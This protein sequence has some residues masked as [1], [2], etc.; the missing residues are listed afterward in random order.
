[1]LGIIPIEIQRSLSSLIAPILAMSRLREHSHSRAHE[2]SLSQKLGGSPDDTQ[3]ALIVDE[4]LGK[5]ENGGITHSTMY[6]SGL[7]SGKLD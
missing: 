6:V 1:M 4:K 3:K 5:P 7:K 2:K